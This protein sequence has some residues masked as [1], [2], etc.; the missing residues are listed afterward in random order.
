M[1][2]VE[3]DRVLVLPAPDLGAL[4]AGPGLEAAGRLEP[5]AE[6]PLAEASF[7]PLVPR[8]EKIFC[9]GMNYKSHIAEMGHEPPSHPDLVR[10][11]RLQ[12]HR[13]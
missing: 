1:A 4:L 2:R 10:E 7:A 8:P 5:S 13:R 9:V 6:L 12:P 3:G 11:V